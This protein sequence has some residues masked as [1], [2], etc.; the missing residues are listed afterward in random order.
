MRTKKL[1]LKPK[2]NLKYIIS[3][4]VFGTILNLAVGVIVFCCAMIIDDNSRDFSYYD[5][6][7]LVSSVLAIL[8][9]VAS[10]IIIKLL[11]LRIKNHYYRSLLYTLMFPKSED[12]NALSKEDLE[13][14]KKMSVST[15]RILSD[16]IFRHFLVMV[17]LMV[18]VSLT[19]VGVA[20]VVF[21]II[22]LLS[23]MS[24]GYY[25][26][27][28]MRNVKEDTSTIRLTQ[29]YEVINSFA[30][31]I[32]ILSLALCG[33]FL[34]FII[35]DFKRHLLLNGSFI[36]C[37]S[38][39]I[40]SIIL[41]IKS[42][43]IQLYLNTFKTEHDHLS[44][45]I[46]LLNRPKKKISLPIN[47]CN[48]NVSFMIENGKTMTVPDFEC[49]SGQMIGFKT[50]NRDYYPSIGM[51]YSGMFPY[52]GM[53]TLNDVQIEQVQDNSIA[54][55]MLGDDELYELSLRQNI[56]LCNDGDIDKVLKETEL[57]I[58]LRFLE[59]GLESN[60]LEV[61]DQL[62]AS[63]E[64][65]IIIARTLY[66]GRKIIILADPFEG[67]NHDL[68]QRILNNI[69]NGYPQSII[70]IISNNDYVLNKCD[71]IIYLD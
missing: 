19:N 51:L 64:K 41:A 30:F 50:T 5:T 28:T 16:V 12:K 68:T 3:I 48:K 26:A 17:L 7:I 13:S 44:N 52:F 35:R 66:G 10:S 55:I 18:I 53:I 31:L 54:G 67:V 22:F 34:Y 45:L 42:G 59:H 33:S 65:R 21:P 70:M 62:S 60:Y 15:I 4:I 71:R 61:K 57:D 8:S 36:T 2:D 14:I 20:F 40:I 47:F 32:I 39:L 46:I 11:S 43:K 24:Y 6:T 69:K 25:K 38:C 58:D 37:L 63:I 27:I 29:A 49:S 56:V 1:I 9:F 23:M